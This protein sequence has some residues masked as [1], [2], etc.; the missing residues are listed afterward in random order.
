MSRYKYRTGRRL[1]TSALYSTGAQDATA[2]SAPDFTFERTVIVDRLNQVIEGISLSRI[3]RDELISVGLSPDM[4]R[5][6]IG[7][8][9]E[10]LQGLAK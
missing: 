2:Q 8:H 10:F 3:L 7:Y 5:E 4:V 1:I 9:I 6:G